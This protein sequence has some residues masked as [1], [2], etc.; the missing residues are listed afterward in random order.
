MTEK[1]IEKEFPSDPLLF[2]DI[3]KFVMDAVSDLNLN[4]DQLNSLALSVAEAASNSVIHGNKKDKSKKVLIKIISSNEE[5]RIIFK[6]FGKGFDPKNIP[7]PT[8][9][10]NILKDSGRGIHIMKTFLTDLKFNFTDDGTETILVLS[11]N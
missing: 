5:V 9:P 2:P 11:R 10:E 3:E 7:D 1:I 6:D 8:A 4:E